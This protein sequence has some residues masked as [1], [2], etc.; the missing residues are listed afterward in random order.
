M[1]VKHDKPVVD[2]L[3]FWREGVCETCHFDR[4]G[5]IPDNGLR[6]SVCHGH[7]DGMWRSAGDRHLFF[8]ICVV[9]NMFS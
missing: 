4:R 7:C 2:N 6:D 9:V 1:T 3:L 5:P 8:G